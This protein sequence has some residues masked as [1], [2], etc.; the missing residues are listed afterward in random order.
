MNMQIGQLYQKNFFGFGIIFCFLTGILNLL[1]LNYI[2]FSMISIQWIA[3]ILVLLSLATL[4]TASKVT[5]Y[6]HR[7]G[8]H[9]SS[10][11]AQTQVFGKKNTKAVVIFLLW[12]TMLTIINIFMAN[13]FHDNFQFMK[14]IE[15][16]IFANIGASLSV[17]WMAAVP[18]NYS[19]FGHLSGVLGMFI[20]YTFEN[21]LFTILFLK[22]AAI[23]SSNYGWW[24]LP[25]IVE[26]FLSTIYMITYFNDLIHANPPAILKPGLWQKF[27]I[28]MFSLSQGIYVLIF[29][30]I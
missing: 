17:T 2:Q 10:F 19:R 9:P 14:G 18:I 22:T 21:I 13:F 20:F 7:F 5:V 16:L 27:W 28:I 6:N 1:V 4:Y 12:A 23:H 25:A 15:M 29:S 26:L 11:I 3:V 24:A 30:Q 8:T